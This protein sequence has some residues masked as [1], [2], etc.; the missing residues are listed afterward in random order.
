MIRAGVSTGSRVSHGRA[1]TG[2]VAASGAASV[3]VAISPAM[4]DTSYT[5]S[6]T[7]ENAAADLRVSCVTA[8]T[9]S[10]VTVLVS[11]SDALNSASGTVHVLAIHD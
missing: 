7:V 4:A 5:V 11:N 10:S 3:A 1:S 8:K 6:A 2:T 9:A